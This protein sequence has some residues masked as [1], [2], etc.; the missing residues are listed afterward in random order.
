MSRQMTDNQRTNIDGNPCFM[1]LI[2][3]TEK[4]DK[5]TKS[6][7]ADTERKY[8]IERHGCNSL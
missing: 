1:L 6:A 2:R 4:T 7:N 5:N 3:T 8:A